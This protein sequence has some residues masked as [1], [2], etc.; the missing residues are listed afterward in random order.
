MP[1]EAARLFLKVTNVRVERL[2]D[3]DE[4][5]AKAEGVN[6]RDGKHVGVEEKMRRS[7]VERFAEIWDRTIKPED[8]GTYGWDA[9]PYVWVIEY[10]RCEKP[11]EVNSN[12]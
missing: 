10:E 12:G 1:K 11:V 7:A 8:I 9:N 4:E 6:F 3:I 5:G 2:Q